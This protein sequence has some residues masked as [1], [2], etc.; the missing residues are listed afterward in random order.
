MTTR[1]MLPALMCLAVLA[2]FVS[3]VSAQFIY[4]ANSGEATV[5]EIDINLNREVARFRTWTGNQ[6]NQSMNLGSNVG[7]APSRI[8][9]D[10]DGNV[11]VLNRMWANPIA[12]PVLF[13][14]LPSLPSGGTDTSH[15]GGDAGTDIQLLDDNEVLPL[16]VTITNGV[17]DPMG[18][19]DDRVE[20]G[21]E[22]GDP[23]TDKGGLG[24][25]LCFDLEGNLWV[26]LNTKA[27]YHKLSPVTR[28]ILATV[29]TSGH[30][31][32]G[33]AVD[34]QGILWS[35]SSGNTLAEIDTRNPT[36]PAVIR[37]HSG[38]GTNYG[39][40]LRRG[41]GEVPRRV[42]LSDLTGRTYIEFDPN[43]NLFSNPTN[44]A[45]LN[46]PTS[47][48][49]AVDLDGNIISGYV[50]GRVVKSDPTGTVL[51]DTGILPAGP[52][53][54]SNDLHGLIIDAH[55]DVWAVHRESFA[56]NGRV[57]KYSGLTGAQLAIVQI[58][59]EP[60]TYGNVLPPNCPCAL[61]GETRIQCQGQNAGVAT[62]SY[63]FTFTN[64][65][66]FPAPA[67][68]VDLSS[69]NA[70][71]NP[72][73]VT[74][75]PVPPNG[76]GTV[77]GTFTV[78]SPQ[79]G[80]TVCLDVRLHGSEGP[81]LWCCPSQQVC[82]H[83]PECRECAKVQGQFKCRPNGTRYLELTITNNG[84]TTAQSV[85]V[86]S[87]TPGVTITPLS[88]PTTFP[89]GTPIVQQFSVAGAAPGQS[90][91]LTVNLHG[92][93][94]PETGVFDWCCTS[95]LKIVYP[96]RPCYIIIDGGVFND[97]NHNGRREAGEIGISGLT[98]VLT[99]GPGE[100]RT[101]ITAAD[102]GYRFEDVEP[103]SYVLS[104]SPTSVWRPVAPESGV[105]KIKI[106]ES[107]DQRFDFGFVQLQP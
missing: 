96:R 13:K 6:S 20:W 107:T 5:S 106:E 37:S 21:I 62:Y 14:I 99:G 93:T 11:Y 98:V 15:D 17:V 46:Q 29:A 8:A 39:I 1:P 61:I 70:T 81:G 68:G 55:N 77:S 82:F 34:S 92:P 102:G 86:F 59:K 97:R 52:T 69:P 23:L 103:G 35:A 22:V 54:A 58:G 51:W 76:Q 44:P 65:S 73:S 30:T 79:P 9:V 75:P 4:V 90:I 28:K 49:I 104:V 72:T 74:F 36:K 88:P 57:V 45:L 48:A 50:N 40:S 84:P 33:C 27:R 85:Q 43:Q 64:Q 56:P 94:D 78:A 10:A 31:P 3:P 12:L 80:S 87:T 67:A 83:L 41:C 7:P 91:D 53:V 71:L 18:I 89:V 47:Y 24:R 105:Y 19:Q 26:G 25:A 38:K 60:Y 100:P 32:Y 95:S 66:P 101:T 16:Q 42:Y 63:G 2:F